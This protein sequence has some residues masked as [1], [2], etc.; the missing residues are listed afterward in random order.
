MKKWFLP[1][2]LVISSVTW[3]Q[4]DTTTPPYKKFPT[5][6][7]LQILLGDSVTKFTKADLARKK[8][9]LF[10]LFSPDC[11]HCQHTAEEMLKYKAELS[12]IQ[13]VMVTMQSINDMNA[14][15]EK[16]R[17]K[18]LPDLVVGKDIYYIMPSYYDVRSLPYLAFYDKKGR[19]IRGFEGTMSMDKIIKQFKEN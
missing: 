15:V 7:P 6:P 2:L 5:H 8:P 1:L 19:L 11:S 17:L 18:E 14:F 13:I 16:Y 4:V 10:M 9:V 3:A 12:G